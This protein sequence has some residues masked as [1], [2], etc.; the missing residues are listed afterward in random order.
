[1]RLALGQ[2]NRFRILTTH[3]TTLLGLQNLPQLPCFYLYTSLCIAGC[4]VGRHQH[5]KDFISLAFRR[6]LLP[7]RG[8]Q[9]DRRGLFP[10]ETTHGVEYY[11]QT[12]TV[13]HGGTGA[14]SKIG[15]D[16]LPTRG[17]GHFILRCY[18][19]AVVGEV[20]NVV[21]RLAAAYGDCAGAESEYEYP[22]QSFE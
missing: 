16:L 10:D 7:R 15:R 2:N 20:A 4:L 1:M 13:G 17:R 5:R 19:S 12:V 9:L 22:F 21:G 6:R 11:L 18:Q 8:S 3:H 14:V